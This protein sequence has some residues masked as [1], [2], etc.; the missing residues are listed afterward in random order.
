M[1][2][3]R[4]EHQKKPRWNGLLRGHS[5]TLR[6]VIAA[7]LAVISVSLAF[8]QLGLVGI[9][10]PGEYSAYAIVM[11]I[12]VALEALFFGPLPAACMGLFAGGVL[13]AHARMMPL[14]YY[15]LV[16]VTPFTSIVLL[17]LSGLLLGLL[18]RLA[19][20][21][22]PG[23][24]RRTIY[25]AIVCFVVSCIYST[26]FA[27]GSIGT[28]IG[29]LVTESF[30]NTVLLDDKAYLQSLGIKYMLRLGDLPLQAIVDALLMTVACAVDAA[31]IKHFD[32]RTQTL[33]VRGMFNAWL[34]AI[35][36]IGFMIMEAAMFYS[37]TMGERAA[38]ST[39]MFNEAA[40]LQDQLD[41]SDVR[42][43]SLQELFEQIGI[44]P[45]DYANV[46][47][48]T[49]TDTVKNYG[50]LKGY[51]EGDDGIIIISN[52]S[53]DNYYIHLSNHAAYMDENADT[54]LGDFL[55]DETIAAIERS[56]ATGEL[57]N[58]IYDP[59]AKL[60]VD[61]ESL[62]MPEDSLLHTE[63]GFLC[64]VQR[65]YRVVTVMLPSSTVFAERQR[66]MA[67]SS[68][69]IL[70]LLAVVF[71]LT[72]RLLS[73]VVAKRI[74]ATNA[75]LERITAGDL[76][77]HVEQSETREFE[78]LAEGINT[79]V[80]ALKG[81]INEAE[82]RMDADLAA[83]K[84]IQ[85][86]ALPTTFPPFPNIPRFD[87]FASMDPAREVGGDFYDFFLLG[88]DS[89]QQSGKLGFL[90]ADVSGKGIPA[91]LFMMKAKTLIRDYLENGVEL[92]EAI[93]N[94]NRMLC[95]GNDANMF[96]TAWIAVLDYGT[97]HLDYVN[98]GH[99]PP[100]LWASTE[101]DPDPSEPRYVREGAWNW[102]KQKSGIPLG[103][104][105]GLPYK[106]HSLDIKPGDMLLLYTDGVS[107]AMD[108]DGSLYGEQRLFELA[109]AASGLHPRTLTMAITESLAAFNAGAEQSDDITILALEYG[110]PPEITAT[111][112]VDAKLA[113]L[114]RVNEF[115]HN[116]L[117]QRFCPQRIQAMIDIAVEELFVNV[118]SYAYPEATAEEPGQVRVSYSYSAEPP[119]I[120]IRLAD[121]G[122]PFDPLSVIDEKIPKGTDPMTLR[123]GGLGI[124][125]ARNSV[126]EMH[127]ERAGESNVV[128]LIKSW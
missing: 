24:V 30:E 64:A 76:D 61:E 124:L 7:I 39:D 98:A 113:E 2:H 33:G 109:E 43:E 28:M 35:T 59:D 49:L 10:T 56:I 36:A 111:I 18:F 22:N 118:A 9:G 8:M 5:S 75:V 106:A 84:S 103:M 87:I 105:D 17:A 100:L 58:I 128:T 117:D 101:D 32:S 29:Q 12:P 114:N 78:S 19:L 45:E 89:G 25:I 120:T 82:T 73:Q 66:I 72:S 96:V 6:F 116:A 54:Y 60:M 77:A 108:V 27:I 90:I 62:D 102:L 93:E 88:D 123:I 20:R 13:L 122:I 4:A 83:A 97:G 121:T 79:T 110:I 26:C 40:Y 126:D 16:F 119:S 44:S 81:W 48:A 71:G 95:D 38:A 91:A 57:Q 23:P 37:V 80:D 92:G 115:I 52:S 14:G 65:G 21:N 31:L 112:T 3:E 47:F 63:L 86:S 68:A 127:Y 51:E 53:T 46:D 125:M 69:S 1:A 41:N 50:L 74:D 42:E 99:N 70:V 55:S 104:Y 85:V 107:E 67:W 34:L 11:L 15:E 94:A